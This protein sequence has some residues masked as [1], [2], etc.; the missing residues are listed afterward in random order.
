MFSNLAMDTK[1]RSPFNTT[2]IRIC[3]NEHYCYIPPQTAIDYDSYE[4]HNSNFVRGTAE[5]LAGRFVTML[6][7]LKG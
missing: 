3:A 5:T 7:S 4:S 1:A 2:V 6:E